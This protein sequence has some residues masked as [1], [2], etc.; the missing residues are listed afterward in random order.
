MKLDNALAMRVTHGC[1][2]CV[3]QTG[4]IFLNF[5]GGRGIQK[6]EELNGRGP[7]SE[8]P[9]QKGIKIKPWMERSQNLWHYM[10]FLVTKTPHQ[11]H[12]SICDCGYGVIWTQ[13]AFNLD[14]AFVQERSWIKNTCRLEEI[15]LEC[16]QSAYLL[17]KKCSIVLSKFGMP[18]CDTFWV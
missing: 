12:P 13:S 1:Y 5:M 2:R 3:R 16:S 6:P 4:I 11:M 8:V 18:S 7:K 14:L 15:Y 17:S 10:P 9:N